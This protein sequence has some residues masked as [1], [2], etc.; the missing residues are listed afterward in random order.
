MGLSG[1]KSAT[2][3]LFGNHQAVVPKTATVDQFTD[4]RK[5]P[6]SF[7]KHFAIALN[8]YLRKDRGIPE[9]QMA[10]VGFETS[11]RLSGDF[12]PSVMYLGMTFDALGLHAQAMETFVKA[13]RIHN[14][15]SIWRA[16]SLS[17]LKA[18]FE[19]LAFDLYKRASSAKIQFNDKIKIYLDSTYAPSS[20]SINAPI[21]R[22]RKSNDITSIEEKIYCSSSASSDEK[23]ENDELERNSSI[24]QCD[25]INLVVDNYLI[26]RIVRDS[27]ATGLDLLSALQLTFGATLYNFSKTK[28]KTDETLTIAT[29]QNRTSSLI[30][31]SI[32]Y[33]LSLASE[34]SSLS[35][36]EVSP[37][38]LLSLNEGSKLFDGTDVLIV[39]TSSDSSN[40]FE[41]EVG[42]NL[43]AS[44]ISF[45]ENE[46]NL[47]LNISLS[48]VNST[49]S[50]TNFQ[51]LNTDRMETTLTGVFPYNKA[52]IVGSFSSLSMSMAD[53]G[54]TGLRDV[55]VAGN[56]FNK[57]DTSATVR[58][59][60]I[61]SIVRLVNGFTNGPK[62]AERKIAED[63]GLDFSTVKFDRYG[64][65]YQAPSIDSLIPVFLNTATSLLN[66]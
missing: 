66:E 36:I 18:G 13:A 39:S 24:N 62:A 48:T 9:L 57:S 30:I 37:S 26:K 10:R 43:E 15:A 54:Q 28:D 31:P 23:S 1:C 49:V 41:K 56:L 34:T 33:A 4:L 22:I 11:W 17:A 2:E 35:S 60:L 12:W 5:Q 52:V 19:R 14:H 58:E 40:K 64:F 50:N 53:A 32:S 7:E 63:L 65:A 29:T 3:T 59:F 45:T 38:I 6:R 44:V 25:N 16:A 46:A 20:S 21:K 61:V 42:V 55:P 8:N 27:S 47:K 51:T